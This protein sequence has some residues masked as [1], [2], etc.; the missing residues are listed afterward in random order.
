MDFGVCPAIYNQNSQFSSFCV[1]SVFKI[2]ALIHSL[3]KCRLFR[4]VLALFHQ[5]IG[6]HDLN[7]FISNNKIPYF[8]GMAHTTGL[9]NI[10]TSDQIVLAFFIPHLDPGIYQ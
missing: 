2:Y 7:A 1:I 10:Q 6:I 4:A 8:T 5:N 3:K 9:F